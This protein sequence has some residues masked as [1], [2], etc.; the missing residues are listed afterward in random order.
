M[1]NFCCPVCGKR[2]F[3]EG[4]SLYCENRHCYDISRSGYVNLLQ[5]QR[6]ADKRHGDDRL[7]VRARRAF[8]DKG[9]YK[10]LLSRLQETIS[11]Y[12]FDGC[13]I[14]DAGCGEC[15][16][17]SNIYEYLS[18]KGI[19]SVMFGADISKDTLAAG[20]KRGAAIELAVASVF[21][22]PIVNNYCNIVLSIFAPFCAEEFARVL[23]D[24][25]IIIRAY[26]LE[27][28][29]LSLKK[30]VYDE[31]YENNPEDMEIA[32]FRIIDRQEIRGIIH[33]G[34]N[35]DIMNL[36]SMTPYYYKTGAADQEKLKRLD[37][38]DTEIEFG[39]LTYKKN[40]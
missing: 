25:G 27:R 21:H 17:T 7:M 30:A 20:A 6:Q 10:P 15:W 24:N 32:G 18:G 11:K 1:S 9:Y 23:A 29:L 12:A 26:V 33:L 2:L 36:F 19:K 14:F 37:E 8:L 34:C 13:R 31:V 22:L 38:L 4:K 35:E 16:Y 28:H 39:I 5:S 3:A 40:S